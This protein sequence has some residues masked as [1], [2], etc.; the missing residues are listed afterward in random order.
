LNPTKI[1]GVCGRLMC[2]LNNEEEV[3]EE[4][5]A[6]MP[7]VGDTVTAEDG[8]RGEVSSINI[9]RETMR[10]FVEVGDER[11]I[12]DY[13]LSQIKE[14]ERRRKQKNKPSQGGGKKQKKPRE[15]AGREKA[16]AKAEKNA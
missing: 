9:L 10:V 2:C 8:V 11:E 4:I 13:H 16:S 3:Y 5:N 6:R 7:S 12:H 14:I 1:S 15:E